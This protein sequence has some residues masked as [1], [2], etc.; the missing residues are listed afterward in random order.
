[1]GPGWNG[2]LQVWHEENQLWRILPSK[3]LNIPIGSIHKYS[4]ESP[5]IS[6]WHRSRNSINVDGFLPS[7]SSLNLNDQPM[8]CSTNNPNI[9]LASTPSSYNGESNDTFGPGWPGRSSMNDIG[10]FLSEAV[11]DDVTNKSAWKSVYDQYGYKYVKSTVSRYRR[12][13]EAI[14]KNQLDS[15]LAIN[16]HK[17]VQRGI[18]HFHA[19]W[20]AT[21]TQLQISQPSPRKR[22]RLD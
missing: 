7:A 20:F 18:T 2:S 4:S 9:D 1:M 15:Y 5:L 17:S 11:K 10:K 16:G 13:L 19:A 12:W 22:V 8:S 6:K 3:Q 14:D 21:D